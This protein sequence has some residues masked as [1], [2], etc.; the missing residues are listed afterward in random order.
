MQNQLMKYLKASQMGIKMNNDGLTR[1]LEGKRTDKTGERD[2][3]FNNWHRHN[4]SKR[5]YATDIDFFE[6]RWESNEPKAKAFVEV[7]KAHVKQNKYI[8]SSNNKAILNL[9]LKNGLKFLIILYE[10]ISENSGNFWVWD[11]KSIT[12]LESYTEI[13]FKSF[14]NQMS[15]DELK[16]FM[17]GL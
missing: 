7:K 4:L 2:L 9:C 8:V 12:E 17:E 1:D 15:N 16:K 14:F 13:K 3:F 5:C 6:Y 10:Q 11:V